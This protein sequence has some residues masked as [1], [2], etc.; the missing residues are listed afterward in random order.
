M[1][2]ANILLQMTLE[3][4]RLIEERIVQFLGHVPSWKERKT[5]RILNRLGESTIY[6]EKQLVGTVYFQPVD[7][8]I[9]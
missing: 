6:Y 7:D 2:D 8:L 4:T 3:R 9:I 1:S 5:F